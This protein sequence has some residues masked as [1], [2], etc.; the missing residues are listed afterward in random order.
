MS[1]GGY[2]KETSWK[3]QK[4]TLRALQLRTCAEIQILLRS[5]FGSRIKHDPIACVMKESL[6]TQTGRTE[7]LRIIIVVVVVI[8][9]C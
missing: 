4:E 9:I 5:F 8:I 2:D 7:L 1:T 6:T 3:T